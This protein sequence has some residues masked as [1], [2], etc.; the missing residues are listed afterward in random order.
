M[1]SFTWKKCKTQVGDD[2]AVKCHY[3]TRHTCTTHPD[4][5]WCM[6]G[7]TKATGA[8]Y[9]NKQAVRSLMDLHCS[10]LVPLTTRGG[11][12]W[13]PKCPSTYAQRLTGTR[14]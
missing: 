9:T 8:C 12:R 5:E 13:P 3:T 6:I 10:A 1:L 4:C 7:E 2:P 14:L 11:V